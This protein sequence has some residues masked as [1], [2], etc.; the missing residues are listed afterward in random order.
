M[1][2]PLEEAH[3]REGFALFVGNRNLSEGFINPIRHSY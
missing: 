3:G 2:G 1:G